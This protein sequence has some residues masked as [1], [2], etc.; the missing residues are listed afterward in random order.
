MEKDNQLKL[1]NKI[2]ASSYY[3][4]VASKTINIYTN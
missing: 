1:L 3:I 4:L 2:F